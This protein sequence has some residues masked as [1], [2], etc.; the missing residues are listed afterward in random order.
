[1]TSFNLGQAVPY[2]QSITL[3]AH[4]E[5]HLVVKEFRT[6]G[7]MAQDFARQGKRTILSGVT[8]NKKTTI[9][10]EPHRAIGF[11]G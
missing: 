8:R 3:S 11:C 10:N 9:Y 5:G 4:R 7:P 1:L 2:K 6:A